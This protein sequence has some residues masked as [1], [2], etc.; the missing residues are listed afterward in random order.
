MVEATRAPIPGARTKPT[1]PVGVFHMEIG[2]D[3]VAGNVNILGA[4]STLLQKE[5]VSNTEEADFARSLAA[6]VKLELEV[7]AMVT[8]GVNDA[9]NLDAR[10]MRSKEESALHTVG[11]FNVRTLIAEKQSRPRVDAIHMV[12]PSSV[13]ILG[14]RGVQRQGGIVLSTVAVEG[15]QRC[16]ERVH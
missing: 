15:E 8:A 3:G 7:S 10:S 5:D 9:R 12:T 2:L 16:D 14:V 4:S 13:P 11:G 6:R 1:W